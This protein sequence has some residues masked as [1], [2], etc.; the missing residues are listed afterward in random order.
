MIHHPSLSILCITGE[1]DAS[2]K[3]LCKYLQSMPHIKLTVKP[4][5]PQDLSAY[6]VILTADR[7]YIPAP[8]LSCRSS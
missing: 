2:L 1:K 7:R 4:V 3:P 8:A 6:H 5:L